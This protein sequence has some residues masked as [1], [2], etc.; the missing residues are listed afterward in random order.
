LVAIIV[1]GFAS[2]LDG[3]SQAEAETNAG[4]DVDSIKMDAFCGHYHMWGDSGTRDVKEPPKC[5]KSSEPVTPNN[6]CAHNHKFAI[7]WTTYVA[8]D[9]SVLV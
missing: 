2:G 7:N 9:L 1:V 4:T 3:I 6:F 8:G 5:E